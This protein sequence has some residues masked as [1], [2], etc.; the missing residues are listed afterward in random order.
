MQIIILYNVHFMSL[1][2]HI[3]KPGVDSWTRVKNTLKSLYS[4]GFFREI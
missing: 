4:I 2:F 3:K 1:L